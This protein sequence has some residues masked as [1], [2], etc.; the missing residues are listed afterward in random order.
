MKIFGTSRQKIFTEKSWYIILCIK[1]FDTRNFQRHKNGNL[2]SFFLETKRFRQ[3][4]VRS[5]FIFHQNFRIEQMGSAR[6]SR[7]TTRSFLLIFWYCDTVRQKVFD[8]LWYNP[9]MIYRNFCS[10]KMSSVHFD[11]VSACFSFRAEFFEKQKSH[12]SCAGF[13]LFS[14]CEGQVNFMLQI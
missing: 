8:I 11:V 12:F 4:F 6:S 7:K 1:F 3:I 13:F 2:I 14:I 5:P 9:A 10:G